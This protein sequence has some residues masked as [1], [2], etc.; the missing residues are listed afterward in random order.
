MSRDRGYDS[1]TAGG[2]KLAPLPRACTRHQQQ[3]RR[4]AVPRMVAT[5][6]AFGW[7]LWHPQQRVRRLRQG[8]RLRRDP[9][10]RRSGRRGE[11]GAPK[12]PAARGAPVLGFAL[13]RRSRALPLAVRPKGRTAERRRQALRM[14]SLTARL[15]RSARCLC[16]PFSLAHPVRRFALTGASTSN[17]SG[18]LP[19]LHPP[20]LFST[21][22]SS[23]PIR[24]RAV[25]REGSAEPRTR[26]G[27]DDPPEGFRTADTTRLPER[28]RRSFVSLGKTAREL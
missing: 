27:C 2:L 11:I 13:P 5:S 14:G 12:P 24:T 22:T 6:A 15:R 8:H 25:L 4:H 10:D 16:G 17:A 18:R 7:R 19:T 20:R 26:P 21:A 3:R 23:G 9:R 1:A 28:S